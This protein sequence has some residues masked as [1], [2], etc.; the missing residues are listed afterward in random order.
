M[1]VSLVACSEHCLHAR[2]DRVVVFD[3]SQRDLGQKHGCRDGDGIG[4]GD[5]NNLGGIDDADV[6]QVG[7]VPGGGVEALP[8]GPAR[9]LRVQFVRHGRFGRADGVVEQLLPPDELDL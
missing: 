7:V 3:V 5:A 8:L 6:V 4:H 2:R 1:P 9:E